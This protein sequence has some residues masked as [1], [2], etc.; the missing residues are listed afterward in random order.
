MFSCSGK[1]CRLLAIHWTVAIQ[2]PLSIGFPEQ[3]YWIEVC[4]LLRAYSDPIIKLRES[5]ANQDELVTMLINENQ[6]SFDKPD[7]G[8]IYTD[9]VSP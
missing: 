3:G 6:S 7:P 5:Q 2:A 9:Q 8:F 1:L 4:F